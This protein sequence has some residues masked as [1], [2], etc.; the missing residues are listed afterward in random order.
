MRLV[1]IRTARS[2]STAWH[3]DFSLWTLYVLY[4]ILSFPNHFHI[5][6]CM[7]RGKKIRHSLIYLFLPLEFVVFSPWW[8]IKKQNYGVWGWWNRCPCTPPY[9]W[10]LD[11]WLLGSRRDADDQLDTS[12]SRQ[13]RRNEWFQVV[14]EVLICVKTNIITLKVIANVSRLMVYAISVP[15]YRW[16]RRSATVA[17][18]VSILSTLRGGHLKQRGLKSF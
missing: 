18:Q 6:W 12:S 16:R 9:S 11:G 5:H 15:I 10:Y 14:W 3:Q 1:P 17:I 7:L 2:A 4:P 8:E 13:Q